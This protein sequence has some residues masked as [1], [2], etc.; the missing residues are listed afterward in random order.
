MLE[1]RDKEAGDKTSPPETHGTRGLTCSSMKR[2]WETSHIK[3]KANQGNGG[4]GK[5]TGNSRENANG[6]Q[7]PGTDIPTRL[8]ETLTRRRRLSPQR[9]LHAGGWQRRAGGRSGAGRARGAALTRAS[10]Q[11][12]LGEPATSAVR[13]MPSEAP[14][15]CF[16]LFSMN[17]HAGNTPGKV[18]KELLTGYLSGKG[19]GGVPSPTQTV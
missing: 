7:T 11:S 3:T 9:R 15:K 10:A 13:E 18:Y 5:E 4:K 16:R 19:G 14:G 8:R 12:R 17:T 1:S 6:R 2:P